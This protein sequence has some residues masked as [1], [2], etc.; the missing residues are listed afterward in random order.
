MLKRLKLLSYHVVNTA[1][2]N[3]CIPTGVNLLDQAQEVFN[4]T[5]PSDVFTLAEQ[6]MITNVTFQDLI[7]DVNIQDVIDGNL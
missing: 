2:A 5:S 3:R 4:V 7:L 6:G 1:V